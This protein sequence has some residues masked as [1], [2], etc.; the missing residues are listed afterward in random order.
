MNKKEETQNIIDYDELEK[1][2]TQII[3]RIISENHEL[4]FETGIDICPSI[5]LE[6]KI[7]NTNKIKSSNDLCLSENDI[8]FPKYQVLISVKGLSSEKEA[9]NLL[10]HLF[11]YNVLSRLFWAKKVEEKLKQLEKKGEVFYKDGKYFSNKLKGKL[12]N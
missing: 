6:K 1:E 8:G 2:V 4:R 9:S 12:L 10:N 3:D 7:K 11:D 5:K